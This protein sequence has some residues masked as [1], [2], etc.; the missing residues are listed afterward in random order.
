MSPKK[1]TLSSLNAAYIDRKIDKIM[2]EDS[3]ANVDLNITTKFQYKK[4]RNLSKKSNISDSLVQE[5][6]NIFHLDPEVR[7]KCQNL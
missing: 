1:P 4:R 3:N 7:L 5:K 6:R 2:E